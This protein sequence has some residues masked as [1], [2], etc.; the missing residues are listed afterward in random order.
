MLLAASLMY[1]RSCLA[2]TRVRR[3]NHSAQSEKDRRDM[4]LDLHSPA[5]CSV[6]FPCNRHLSV[7]SFKLVLS[8]SEL[9]ARDGK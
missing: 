6:S 7:L 8:E 3:Q 5:V 9:Y 2:K 1:N 4:C